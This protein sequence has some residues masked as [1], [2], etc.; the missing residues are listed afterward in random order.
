MENHEESIYFLVEIYQAFSSC[1]ES[2]TSKDDLLLTLKLKRAD[3]A[4]P[5]SEFDRDLIK[6]R[7]LLTYFLDDDINKEAPPA[8]VW[9][10][11][12]YTV[13]LLRHFGD[14]RYPVPACLI[15]EWLITGCWTAKSTGTFYPSKN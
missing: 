8:I 1:S 4:D 13:G 11:Q 7:R 9:Q 12:D 10:F 5:L 3:L 14:L 2:I 15:P 6:V